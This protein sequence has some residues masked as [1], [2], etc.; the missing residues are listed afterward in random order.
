MVGVFFGA[1]GARGRRRGRRTL[2]A[3]A[4]LAGEH[5]RAVERKLDGRLRRL[6]HLTVERRHHAALAHVALLRRLV[7]READAHHPAELREDH[8]ER[9]EERPHYHALGAALLVLGALGVGDLR[10]RALLGVLH[11][12]VHVDEL[13]LLE[14]ARR[15]GVDDVEEGLGGVRVRVLDDRPQLALRDQVVLVDLAVVE[16]HHDDAV[17]RARDDA[18]LA[19][20]VVEE[21]L[22]RLERLAPLERARLPLGVVAER[23]VPLLRGGALRRGRLDDHG[24]HLDR[25]RHALDRRHRRAERTGSVAGWMRQA[26][27]LCQS[28]AG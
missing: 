18:T 7:R 20:L 10:P 17:R 8:D 1:G 25:S 26:S 19:V 28:A 24:A 16:L 2:E 15:V 23:L 9:G 14:H 5:R 6:D 22:L 27:P 21:A 11:H 13:G 3:L 12:R 4:L